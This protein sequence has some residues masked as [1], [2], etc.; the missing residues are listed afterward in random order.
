MGF[1][2]F[3]LL[4]SSIVR[5]QVENN[6]RQIYMQA[7]EEYNIGRFDASIQLLDENMANFSGALK[8]VLIAC[9]RC[10]IW[11]KIVCGMPNDMLLFF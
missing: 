11:A 4:M 1:V 9:F 5:A 7:E 2:F 3:L 8:T 6:L 10:A